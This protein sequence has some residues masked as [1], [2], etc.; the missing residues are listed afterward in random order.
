MD[1]LGWGGRVYTTIFE[2]TH[3][4]DGQKTAPFGLKPSQIIRHVF[5][6]HLLDAGFFVHGNEGI[7]QKELVIP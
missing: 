7:G 1:D 5:S 6:D 3:I 4:V 2:N